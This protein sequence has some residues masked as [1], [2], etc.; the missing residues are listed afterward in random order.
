MQADVRLRSPIETTSKNTR[1]RVR[2][3]DP[4]VLLAQSRENW[5]FS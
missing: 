1:S 5:L 4:L 3:R 2:V